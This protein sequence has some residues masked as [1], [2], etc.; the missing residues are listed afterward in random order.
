MTK[1]SQR[2][3]DILD[4]TEPARP[5]EPNEPNEPSDE[6][7]A[8]VRLTLGA[9]IEVHRCLG[10]GFV[11]SVYEAAMCIELERRGIAYEQQVRAPVIYKGVVVGE[12]FIDLIVEGSLIVELKCVAAFAPVHLAQTLSYLKAKDLRVGLLLNFQMRRL[13]DGGIKRVVNGA[14]RASA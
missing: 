2:N 6:L 8:V 3:S 1:S 10:P 13:N 12:H 9:A 4:W 5:N 7:D 14:R 11:E